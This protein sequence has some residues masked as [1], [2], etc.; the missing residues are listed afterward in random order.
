MNVYIN[1]Y[2]LIQH[3]RTKGSFPLKLHK[4]EV[5]LSIYTIKHDLVYPLSYATKGV[6]RFLLR[7]I[8]F[9]RKETNQRVVR[10]GPSTLRYRRRSA[11]YRAWYPQ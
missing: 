5:A 7:H 4:T 2:D 8:Y 11:S 6:F 3:I 1:I 9:P 10:C